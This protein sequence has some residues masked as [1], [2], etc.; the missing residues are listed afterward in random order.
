MPVLLL[1]AASGFVAA[2]AQVIL[3]REL[4][5]VFDG[6]EL[7]LG[8]VLATWLFW[9]AVGSLIGRM[10][11]GRGRLGSLH[12]M[13]VGSGALSLCQVLVVRS[14][15][16]WLGAGFGEIL[17]IVPAA[18]AA[19]LALAPLCVLVGA[20]FAVACHIAARSC[21]DAARRVYVAEGVGFALGGVAAAFAL[22]PHLSSVGAALLLVLAA[23]AASS[24]AAWLAIK[25]PVLHWSLLCGAASIVFAAFGGA[26]RLETASLR[27]QWRPLAVLESANSPHGNIVAAQRGEQ[28]SFFVSGKYVA[29]AGDPFAAEQTAHLCLLQ[30]RRPRSALLIGG[31][32]SGIMPH[33]LAHGL[34]RLVYVELDPRLTALVRRRT[35]DDFTGF[36]DE[37]AHGV[38]ADARL[39]C[40]RSSERFDLIL[41]AVPEPS[42][43]LL[44]RFYTLEFFR[45]ARRLLTPSGVLALSLPAHADYFSEEDLALQGTVY[46]TLRAV[47]PNVLVTPTEQ[48]FF[49]ASA[50]DG[51]SLDPDELIRRFEARRVKAAHFHPYLLYDLLPPDRVA[52]VQATLRPTRAPLTSDFSPVACFRAQRLWNLASASRRI[53]P[54]AMRWLDENP[55]EAASGLL[56]VFVALGLVGLARRGRKAAVLGGLA[57]F[58]LAGMVVEVALLPGE[59]GGTA[60]G[61]DLLGACAGAVAAGAFLLPV[62]GLAHASYSLAALFAALGVLSV[63]RARRPRVYPRPPL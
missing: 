19:S 21:A 51:L 5:V 40:R 12:L 59:A 53:P 6:N 50:G 8:L 15:R 13:L 14:A 62:L 27:A 28:V 34:R 39:W 37:R 38:F 54:A 33:M 20:Q 24:G 42:T 48:R 23:S 56:A 61:A 44:T 35:D 41:L 30:H 36:S 17:P 52:H 25:R 32:A 55:W 45:Q 26:G 1:I 22:V 10:V 43:I 3:I 63:I 46:R 58:G 60:Y 29:S 2:A 7:I 11:P 18:A 49:F 47:F 4:L 57:A 31:T 9:V 16:G